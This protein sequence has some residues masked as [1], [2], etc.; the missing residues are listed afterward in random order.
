MIRIIILPALGWL[1]TRSLYTYV[2]RTSITIILIDR[3]HF[4]LEQSAEKHIQHIYL[5]KLGLRTSV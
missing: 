4:N 5:R 2:L 3:H 1:G